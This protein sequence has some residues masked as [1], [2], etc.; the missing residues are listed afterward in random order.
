[1]NKCKSDMFFLK[2]NGEALF[3]HLFLL[4][5]WRILI[6]TILFLSTKC[7]GYEIERIDT[8]LLYK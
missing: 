5:L 4:P 7:T 1:M 3:L 6:H 8:T 2:N